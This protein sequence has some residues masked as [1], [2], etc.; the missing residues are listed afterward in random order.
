MARVQ[1]DASGLAR[2]E[3]V[4][5]DTAQGVTKAVAADARLLCPVRTGRLRDSIEPERI[6]G[7]TGHVVA[8]RPYAAPVELGH[9]KVLWGRETHE[10]VPAQPYLRP[11]LFRVRVSL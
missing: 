3:L 8:R 1:L 4:V 6:D 5:D 7:R 10:Y 9:R 2:L 11:A